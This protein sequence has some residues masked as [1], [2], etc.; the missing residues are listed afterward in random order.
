V[1][2]RREHDVDAAARRAE[3]HGVVDELVEQLRDELA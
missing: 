1:L 2:R 3:A